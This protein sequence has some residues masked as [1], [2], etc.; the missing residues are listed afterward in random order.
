MVEWWSGGVFL[1]CSKL[2]ELELGVVKPPVLE[3]IQ[4]R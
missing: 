1:L 2:N 3:P 4:S